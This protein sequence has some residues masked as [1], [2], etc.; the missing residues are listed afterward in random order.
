MSRVA[1]L[2]LRAARIA[3]AESGIAT[4]DAA[5]V[6]GSG[7]GDVE[8]HREIASRLARTE[9]PRRVAPTLIPKLMASTVSANLVKVLET[10]GPSFTASAACA[11]GAYNILLAAQL[12]EL[13]PRKG[14]DRRRGRDQ[15]RTFLRRLRRDGRLQRQERAPRGRLGP[16]AADRAG[17]VFAEG[18]GVVVLERARTPRPAGR[19]S[20]GSSAVRYV[21]RRPGRDGAPPP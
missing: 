11:G 20:W 8:T 3:V 15:R 13:G 1:M 14:G 17:F 7:T 21:E 10:S 16:Y 19:R 5:V 9:G 4:R 12:I 2:A 6:V 18:A